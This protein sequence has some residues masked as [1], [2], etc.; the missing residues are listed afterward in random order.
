MP[1]L[2]FLNKI[3]TFLLNILFP[4][5]CVSCGKEGKYL[6]GYCNRRI[7]ERCNKYR[8]SA[9][10]GIYFDGTFSAFEYNKKS[11]ILKLI[12]LLKY[13][14]SE[15]IAEILSGILCAHFADVFAE[16]KESSNWTI[17]F[18][19][20]YKKRFLW[21]GFNQAELIAKIVARENDVPMQK[22]LIKRKNTS[23]QVGLDSIGR[24]INLR[25]A[26]VISQKFRNNISKNVILIDDVMTTG[27]TI[28]ECAK[29]LKTAG[30]KK[31]YGM[32]LMKRV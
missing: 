31:V 4:I 15:E 13:R 23:T 14:F 30:A 9:K 7:M 16:I 22:Y 1:T 6:C 3:L 2:N 27:A 8:I 20:I 17:T 12:E 29:A 24:I 10:A 11:V 5:C 32:V 18:V 25:N 26:F 28:N 21:R 19:P